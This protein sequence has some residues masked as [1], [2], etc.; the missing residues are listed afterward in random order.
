MT[1]KISAWE[2]PLLTRAHEPLAHPLPR[3]RVHVNQQ[4]LENAYDC[5]ANI[6]Y[7]HSRTFYLASGLLPQEKRRAARALYAFCRITDDI[8]DDAPSDAARTAE[9]DQWQRAIIGNATAVQHASPALAWADAQMNFA[10]PRGYAQQLIDGVARDLTKTHYQTF[11]ELAD[12][13][14][15]VASTVGLMAMHIIGFRSRD[16]IPYA[17]KLGVALQITN[18]LRDVEEDYQRGRI[19]LPSDELESFGLNASDIEAYIRSGVYDDRW[20]SFM[21]FQIQRNRALYQ[22]SRE[23]IAMLAAD[24]RFAIA[25]AADL[26]CAILDDIEL[27]DYNVF[28]RRAHLNLWGKMRRLPSIWWFSQRVTVA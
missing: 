18:I 4:E 27:H 7:A 9:L 10:I 12:Y 21:R 25:A 14:Y 13:A 19:Y 23:G 5:C 11:D 26:Y 8:V 3:V 22:E 17:V 15:G 28:N 1:L 24:G 20:R 16:A 6:T 2:Y